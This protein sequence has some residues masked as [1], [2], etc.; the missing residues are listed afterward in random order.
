MP[1]AHGTSRMGV[2][3]PASAALPVL[4]IAPHVR[5]TEAGEIVCVLRATPGARCTVTLRSARRLS[6]RWLGGPPRLVRLGVRTLTMPAAGEARVT[7]RL[8]AD[9]L[10]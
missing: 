8:P 6:S 7:I 1:R 2:M 4:R 10:A 5:A 9:R 3:A